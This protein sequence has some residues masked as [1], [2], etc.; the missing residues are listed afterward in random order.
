MTHANLPLMLTGLEPKHLTFARRVGVPALLVRDAGHASGLRL[1]DHERFAEVDTP[2]IALLVEC[3]HHWARST[4]EVAIETA[5]RFLAASGVLTANEAARWL[6][7]ETPKQQTVLVTHRIT[8][9]S[10][11]FRFNVE[12]RGLEVIPRGGTIIARDGGKAIRTPYDN[13]VLVM[14]TRRF[15]RGQTAVRLGHFED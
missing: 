11:D 15:A 6:G 10:E 13:C 3:G 2:P 5:W 1:R 4:A 9:S 8:A 7:Q 14:P 12:F